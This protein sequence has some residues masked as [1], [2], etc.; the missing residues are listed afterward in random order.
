MEDMFEIDEEIDVLVSLELVHE[1]LDAVAGNIRRWKWTIIGLHS[2]LQGSMVLALQG[3]HGLNTLTEKTAKRW[4]QAHEQQG[5][6]FGEERLDDFL[7]LYSKIQSDLMLMYTNS[8]RFV[9]I[10]T[11]NASV[12]W[13]ND[14]RGRLTHF[15]RSGWALS[16]AS[17]PAK[18][19]DVLAIIEFL[20]FESGNVWWH[21]DGS[22]DT[23]K[24]SC[25]HVRRQLGELQLAYTA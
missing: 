21:N 18:G 4:I 14:I 23:A 13:L 24:A 15:R 25:L 7:N 20:L 1:Q 3:T 9:P 10:G 8:R 2:A 11:Q 16:A 5:R 6:R 12:E 17:W 19:L 22:E